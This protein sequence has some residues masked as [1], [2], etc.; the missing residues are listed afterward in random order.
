MKYVCASLIV[1]SLLF[2]LV[3][4]TQDP[5]KGKRPRD[6]GD[7]RWVSVSPDIY[8]DI[9]DYNGSTERYKIKGVLKYKNQTI[10]IEVG[11]EKKSTE[12]MFIKDNN[13][14]E[15]LFLG[16]CVFSSD[17]LV[18]SVEPEYDYL[19]DGSIKEVTFIKQALPDEL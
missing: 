16:K 8:F 7:A 14:H 11:F 1:F 3:S 15:V 18:V 5:Y 9:H 19:F 2:C 6:Y 12:V 10:E 17:K 4:C 13:Q